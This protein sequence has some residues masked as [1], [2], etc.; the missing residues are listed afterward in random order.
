MIPLQAGAT[1]TPTLLNTY[2]ILLLTNTAAAVQH[3]STERNSTTEQYLPLVRDRASS[4]ALQQPT[5]KAP[6][7]VWIRFSRAKLR[8]LALIPAHGTCFPP[9]QHT[10]MTRQNTG[11]ALSACSI[12]QNVSS[13]VPKNSRTS[14]T[15]FLFR[16]SQNPPALLSRHLMTAVELRVQQAF[17]TA[18]V[19]SHR[20]KAIKTEDKINKTRQDKEQEQNHNPRN[21]R[22]LEVQYSSAVA[23]NKLGSKHKKNADSQQ[24][25]RGI[26]VLRSFQRRHH[27]RSPPPPKKNSELPPQPPSPTQPPHQTTANPSFP[28]PTHSIFV[29]TPPSPPPP[30]SPSPHS[31]PSIPSHDGEA[32]SVGRQQSFT[33]KTR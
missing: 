2:A 21:G 24:C 20:Q 3:R 7:N 18:T 12:V 22:V 30:T 32:W 1:T 29:F 14:N 16:R 13:L 6:R 5:K 9:Q 26:I 27:Q 15:R 17:A 19:A 8:Q 23:P 25:G 11:C 28:T 10:T 33:E 31:L 4:T